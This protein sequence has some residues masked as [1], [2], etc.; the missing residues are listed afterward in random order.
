MQNL[1]LKNE[2]KLNKPKKQLKM[3]DI[4]KLYEK[5]T[6][7]VDTIG[8]EY[9]RL[10]LDNKTFDNAKYSDIENIISHFSKIMG[11]EIVFDN[12]TIIGAKSKS[13]SSISLE[14]GLQLEI[15]L[16]PHN[17]ILNIDLEL[18]KISD[19]IE[20]IAR[21]YNVEF[22]GYGINPKN[23]VDEINLLNKERYKLMYSYLPYCSRGELASKM[24]KKTAGIQINVD[25][26]DENDCYNK[27]KFLNLI[28]P[29]MAGLTANS[30]F[31]S[32]KMTN[33]ISNRANVWRFTGENRCNLFYKDVFNKTFFNLF[34]KPLF[35]SYVNEVIKTPMIFIIRDEKAVPILGKINFEEFMKHG[36]EGYFATI[37]DYITHQS[38]CFPDVRLKNYIEIRNHDSST[39]NMALALCAFYK[40][41]L[42][43]PIQ[44]LLKTFS[45]LKIDKIEEYN[46]KIITDGLDIVIDKDKFGWSIIVSLL[47]LAKDGLNSKERVYLEPIYELVIQKKTQSEILIDMNIET[48]QDLVEFINP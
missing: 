33:L 6:E 32:S 29:F 19:L 28:M 25:Y 48:V 37:D 18:T 17:S 2:T 1:L 35:K 31:E 38:L 21:I 46:K 20:K 4:L 27:L 26:K 3:A 45:Y 11:W 12:N 43:H 30:P 41:L 10:S 44:Q 13:G 14:P 47:N 42:N 40:G 5:N 23:N 15:S 9:E 16:K 7:S 34:K 8:L 22:L 24:M 39:P 36:F